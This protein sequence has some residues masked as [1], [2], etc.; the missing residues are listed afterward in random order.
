MTSV[1][2]LPVIPSVCRTQAVAVPA[3]ARITYLIAGEATFQLS[4]R[5]E[6]QVTHVRHRACSRAKNF[7]KFAPH[8]V[9]KSA[10]S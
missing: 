4:T 1:D 7:R 8:R 5:I 3:A 2:L 6:N 9:K 10:R